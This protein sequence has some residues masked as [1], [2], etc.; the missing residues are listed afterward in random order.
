MVEKSVKQ[1]S[2]LF[3]EG[4]LAACQLLIGQILRTNPE[5]DEALQ[6]AGLLKLRT[7]DVTEAIPLLED[8]R[9]INPGN[10]DHHNNLALGYSRVGRYE[11]AVQ[12]T[13]DALRMAP[14]RQIFW[15]NCAV[16]LRNK[17][18]AKPIP[19]EQREKLLD[20]AHDALHKALA[21]NPQTA[22]VHANI[23]SLYAERHKL[24]ESAE[25]YEKALEIDPA[26]SGVHVDLSYVYF[27]MGE[28]AKA[29][30]HYEYRMAHYPQAS[31]WE[32][33]FP[34]SKRWDGK[35]PLDDKTV[36][37]F[38]EQGC[39]D[40]IHFARYL[41]LLKT[42]KL[43]I[44]CHDP[45]KDLLAPFGETYS[46]SQKPPAYDVSIPI[47]SLPFLLGDP[48]TNDIYLQ[49][50][51]TP[52]L[53]AYGNDLKIGICWAGNPQHPG[54]RFRSISLHEFTPLGMA[55]VKL[56][57]LQKDYRPR[58]YHD[59]DEVIDLCKDGPRVVDLS[60]LLNNFTDTMR[61]IAAMDLVISVD[62][63]VLH[64]AGAMGKKTWAL[65]PYSPD[66]RWGLHGSSTKLYSS[67]ELFRQ[68]EKN[69]W[70]S[71]MDVVTGRLVQLLCSSHM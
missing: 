11:E 26:L 22:S 38:C 18:C 12:C 65:L 25:M 53:S 35:V 14:G 51:E 34:S 59:R 5:H 6:V 48:S 62:T 4:N 40:A 21:L 20:E 52:D 33:V 8:A 17:A 7:G 58:K 31:R 69:D 64:L 13:R 24:V 70:R 49:Q 56:F 9:T 66:W 55:G 28:F 67:M 1:A 60:P 19:K 63:A 10:P 68:T 54:D 44:C 32:K 46:M 61:F 41:P 23:G 39:G 57:S 16:Q 37:V 50:P 71:V 27:L 29:W 43:A 36:C 42:K 15:V 45:L 2:R 47:M 30:P 3:H